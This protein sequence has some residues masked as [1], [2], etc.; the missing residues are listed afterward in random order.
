[1]Y[2]ASYK[3]TACY[4]L[5]YWWWWVCV[6]FCFHVSSTA[7]LNVCGAC[8]GVW[9]FPLK[10][11]ATTAPPYDVIVIEAAGLNKESQI[12]FRLT[13]LQEY[14]ITLHVCV[15]ITNSVGS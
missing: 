7:E 8:G 2:A 14:V 5:L 12:R 11:L 1:M 6:C 15:T 13:S 9:K 3:K 10:L 4:S